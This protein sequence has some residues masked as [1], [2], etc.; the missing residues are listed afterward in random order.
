M[1][2]MT[3]IID[4]LSELITA[5]LP[6]LKP[7]ISIVVGALKI[8]LGVLQTIIGVIKE[9]VG[10]IQKMIDIANNAASTVT[11]AIDDITPWTATGGA[12]ESQMGK[13]GRAAGVGRGSGG[14]NV[15]VNVQSADPTEVMR[16]IRRWS[17]NNGGSGPFNRGLDR[18]TA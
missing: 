11:G 16:A 2:M 17:R 7:A 13:S 8:F 5:I 18:S 6:L 14:A 12:P 1:P 10:W 15:T 3:P 4:I 9:V